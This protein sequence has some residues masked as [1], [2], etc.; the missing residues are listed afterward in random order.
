MN[1]RLPHTPYRF[2]QRFGR[3]L[4]DVCLM[5]SSFASLGFRVQ[6]VSR[7]RVIPLSLPLSVGAWFE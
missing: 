4:V 2:Q 5:Y 1:Q 3:A 6:L 7:A